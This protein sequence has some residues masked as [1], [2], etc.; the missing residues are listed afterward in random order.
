MTAPG[1]GHRHR[2]DLVVTGRIAT[3]AG[4]SGLGWVEA[5]A[6]AD[7]RI[8]A[9]GGRPAIAG[10][11]GPGTQRIDL[12][13]DEVAIPGLTDAHL[14]LADAAI[15]ETDLDLS[16]AASLESGLGRI[17][18][19]AA[20]AGPGDWVRGHG[21]DADRW[22]G[23][24][25]AGD[26]ELVAPGRLIA[27]WAHDH[28]ALWASERAVREAGVGEGTPDPPGGLI[29][30]HDDGRPTGILHEAAARLVSASIP[31]PSPDAVAA[32]IVRLARR[33]LAAGV[34]AVHDPGSVVPD[35][36]L[37]VGLPA[38]ASLAE[39]GDLALRV[40]V[41][42]REEGL[43]RAIDLGL[44]SGDPIGPAAGRARVGWLKL[45]ADGTLGSRTAAML[46][47]YESEPGRNP[48]P[49]DGRGLF[50]TSPVDLAGLAARAAEAGIAAQIHAIGDRAVRAALDAL[51]PTGGRTTLVP[52]VE[53]VQLVAAEDLGRFARHGIAASVQPV[54]LASDLA[55]AR[56]A[57]GARAETRGYPWGA[58]AATG[59]LIPFG[60]D[61]PVE[62]W[63]PWPGIETAVTRA[64]RSGAEPLS[65]RQALSLDRALRAACVDAPR[66]AGERDRGTLEPGM[67]AD[68]VVIPAVILDEP[69]E[70][71]GPL[72]GCRP[73]M[74][75]VDG[76]VAAER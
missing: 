33:L 15:G 52:R 25:T 60:T 32:A 67:R 64:A 76:R 51:V 72:G 20:A 11:E 28:H 74:T 37:R 38:Y 39:A 13:P 30:R 40:H 73:R 53:H 70:P 24:P 16:T 2:A 14:H 71:D 6:I 44:R 57:W 49:L 47:P 26:L 41:A 18:E 65:P 56:V 27:L 61:A 8:I 36:D 19:Y 45:F 12:A 4:P 63:D 42:V 58:L 7:G 69:V 29:R 5:L 31:A 54:H 3:L 23:W 34:V 55:A 43:R 17:A 75:L 50:L 59:A 9:A 1:G 21:W 22:R 46:D 35:P 68:L 62:P 66:S 48:T 10:L